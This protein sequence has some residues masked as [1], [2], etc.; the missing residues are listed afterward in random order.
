[1]AHVERVD[2]MVMR[3]RLCWLCHLERLD[4]TCL[5]ECV[6]VCCPLGGKCSVEGEKLRWCDVIRN[7]IWSLTG[8]MYAHRGLSGGCLW[9]M[10]QQSLVVF[11]ERLKGRKKVS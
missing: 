9:K 7:A 1:M 4:D 3:R 8:V 10:E 5:P 11:L 2:V 6:H